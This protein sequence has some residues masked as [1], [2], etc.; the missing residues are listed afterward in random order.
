MCEVSFGDRPR[1]VAV[2]YQDATTIN[3]DCL[4]GVSVYFKM[5]HLRAGYGDARV[6]PGGYG[7]G[8]PMLYDN[9]CRLRQLRRSGYKFDVYGSFSLRFAADVR[10]A[11]L[12]IL[13]RDTR[14]CFS[15]GTTLAL[16]AQSL[17]DAARSRVC[18]DLPGNGPLC[19]RLVDYLGAGCCVVA[20]RHEAVL[21]S[22]LS[23]RENIVYCADDLSD[24]A[25]LCAEYVE[26]HEARETVATNA[27][28]FFDEHLHYV[29]L[30]GYYIRVCRAAGVGG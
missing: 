17:L 28:R 10:R 25:D 20:R 30:A 19:Y 16:Y 27:A 6:V 21:H 13:E 3:E 5:Q 18:V 29:Q 1:P 11:A 24:L 22:Q 26:D 9:Y 2:D 14:F 15:G 7:G 12:D 23:D 4:R 8:K